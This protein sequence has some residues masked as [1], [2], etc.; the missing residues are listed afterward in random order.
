MPLK[1]LGHQG[2]AA[3]RWHIREAHQACMLNFPY[4][5]KLP[6]VG[7]DRHQYSAFG[8]GAVEERPVARIGS[9]L[10]GLDVMPPRRATIPPDDGQ[11]SDRQEISRLRDRHGGQRVLGDD[12][13]RVCGTRA[14]V[15]RLQVGVILQDGFLRNS[16]SASCRR[17]WLSCSTK[18]A[19]ARSRAHGVCYSSSV[20]TFFIERW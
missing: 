16:S 20:P 17:W 1:N 9:T 14:N 19:T 5:D 10:Q 15:V 13:M 12:R 4:I 7:I 11:R 2:N 6:E 3:R 8:G 18:R